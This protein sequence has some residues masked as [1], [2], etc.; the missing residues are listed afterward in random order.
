MQIDKFSEFEGQ[1]GLT[2]RYFAFD[3]DDNILHMPTK[4]HMEQKV[5]DKWL[6]ID[7]STSKFAEVRKEEDYQLP[8]ADRTTMDE[9]M[10]KAFSDFRDN[11][12][13]GQSAFIE[14]VQI[15]LK[16]GRLAPAWDDFLQCLSEGAIFSIITARGHEPETL[17]A[18]VKYVI[19]NYL[20]KTPSMNPGRT[21]AD[22]MYQN[23]KKY[24][25]YFDELS[26]GEEKEL[27]GVP[28][29][30][31]L[32]EEYL[33]H[34]DFFGVSSQSFAQ[35]FGE[36]SAY[37]PEESK[38][39]AIDYCIEKC[40]SW[41][42][43]L[44]EKL[45]IPVQVKFGMSD[46]DPKNSAHIMDYFSE[47]SGL[48]NALSLYFFYTGKDTQ[49]GDKTMTSGEKTKFQKPDTPQEQIGERL[50]LSFD[51]WKVNE[52][53]HQTPGMESSILPHTDNMTQ[54]LYPSTNDAPKDDYH[55][56]LKN[57]TK[58]AMKLHKDGKRA[59]KRKKRKLI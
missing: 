47:K 31:P 30:N 14:D 51:L 32:I 27:K 36:G 18:G 55:H 33:N 21:L 45:K 35:Q 25:F 58:M 24:K 1:Q 37:N 56:R 39:K 7:V 2:L 4:I 44:E 50:I 6:P 20:A 54:R 13:R 19:D 52:T 9:A 16:E 38:K 59:T 12:P 22:D 17:K 3:W 53:S 40:L 43:S 5:G 49:V 48:S 10:K 26:G 57:Q 15:G 8:G 23:I 28:S 42:A 46:D 11:G 34:C 41:A 29:S